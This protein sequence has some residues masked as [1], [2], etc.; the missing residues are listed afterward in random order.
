MPLVRGKRKA[1]VHANQVRTLLPQ[2]VHLICSR[3]GM[4]PLQREAE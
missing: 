3:A 2:H 1:I 4:L